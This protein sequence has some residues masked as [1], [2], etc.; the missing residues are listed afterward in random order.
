[1]NGMLPAR[2]CF[3]P[4][5]TLTAKIDEVVAGGSEQVDPSLATCFTSPYIDLFSSSGWLVAVQ[6]QH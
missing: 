1:M 4:V 2:Q 6:S 5:Y 3:E